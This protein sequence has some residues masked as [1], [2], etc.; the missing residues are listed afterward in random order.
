MP[1][2]LSADN[3]RTLTSL[4]QPLGKHLLD[5]STLRQLLSKI[6]TFQDH[7]E[8]GEMG[9]AAQYPPTESSTSALALEKGPI[10]YLS[11]ATQGQRKT[12]NEIMRRGLGPPTVAQ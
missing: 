4:D 7:L 1:F 10:G 3:A 5:R 11:Y 6:N 2:R 9:T 8:F 12:N